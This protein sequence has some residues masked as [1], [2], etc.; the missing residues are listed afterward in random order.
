MDSLYIKHGL[1]FL[2]FYNLV[3]NSF[4]NLMSTPTFCSLVEQRQTVLSEHHI[5]VKSVDSG[6][7]MLE[8]QGNESWGKDIRQGK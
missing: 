5:V 8:S 6:T 1:S 2:L 3:S 7:R 4:S